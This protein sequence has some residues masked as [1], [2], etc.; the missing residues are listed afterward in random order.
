MTVLT[1]LRFTPGEAGL[2]VAAREAGVCV[3]MGINEINAQASA[4]SMHWATGVLSMSTLRLI[5]KAGLSYVNP[6]EIVSAEGDK[7]RRCAGAAHGT[8]D[9][10]QRV[11]ETP[12]QGTLIAPE[13]WLNCCSEQNR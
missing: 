5:A 2:G 4:W 11:H 1:W 3:A 12:A 6:P 13:P 7:L 10:P 8:T 9:A